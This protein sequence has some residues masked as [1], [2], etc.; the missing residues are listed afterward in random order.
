M[1]VLLATAC[2]L[3][4]W[5]SAECDLFNLCTAAGTNTAIFP[6]KSAGNAK[7]WINPV[8]RL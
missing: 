4:G 7:M 3:A 5:W 8:R 6:S 1:A 2:W